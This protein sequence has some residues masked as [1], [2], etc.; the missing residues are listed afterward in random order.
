[1]KSGTV[2]HIF[3]SNV[4]HSIRA[5]YYAP[6]LTYPSAVEHEDQS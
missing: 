5:N 2:F 4:L 1:M 3:C 6:L